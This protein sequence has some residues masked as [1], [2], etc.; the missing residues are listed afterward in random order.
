MAIELCSISRLNMPDGTFIPMLLENGADPNI[1]FVQNRT[2]LYLAVE[3]GYRK[4]VKSLLDM[5]ADVILKASY[6]ETPIVTA[7]KKGSQELEII[8]PIGTKPKLIDGDT[9]YRNPFLRR[10]LVEK[11]PDFFMGCLVDY[12]E[13]YQIM[14]EAE[15][16]CDTIKA[17]LVRD[18]KSLRGIFV[19]LFVRGKGLND[20]VRGTDSVLR[21]SS[22]IRVCRPEPTGEVQCIPEATKEESRV[23]ANPKIVGF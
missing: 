4:C 1:V 2:V 23:L 10:A 11:G 20:F 13:L 8:R 17:N 7:S 5:G 12:F 19:K 15:H 9:I 6:G 21:Q 16:F 22:T 14:D 3:R 18:V